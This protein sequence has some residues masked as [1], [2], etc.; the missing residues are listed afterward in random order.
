VLGLDPDVDVQ[1]GTAGGLRVADRAELVEQLVGDVRDPPDPVERA[2]RHRVEVDPPLV[3][4]L[5]V[6]A[7]AVPRVELDGRHLHRPGHVRDLGDAQFVGGPVVARELHPHG[8]HPV[9]SAV[10]QPLLVHLLA[11]HAVGEPVQ[12]ARPLPQRAHDPVSDRQVVLHQV[13]LGLAA[14]REVHPVRIRDPDDALPDLELDRR[15]LALGSLLLGR[16]RGP[17]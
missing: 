12:H 9:R 2:V 5:G 1:A 4:L 17:R 10:R 6:G 16:T 15:R 13:E 7:A 3:G 11:G 14:R 8:L